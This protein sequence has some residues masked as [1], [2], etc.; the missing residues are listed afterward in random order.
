MARVGPSAPGRKDFGEALAE[1]QGLEQEKAARTPAQQKIDSN[2][3]FAQHKRL[4]RGG[5]S[6]RRH[7]E[8]AVKF[9]LTTSAE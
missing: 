7:L 1:I 2:L 5:V 8:P 9:E 3:V 6:G 4:D